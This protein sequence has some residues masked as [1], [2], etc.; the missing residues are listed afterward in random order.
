MVVDVGVGVT[1]HVATAV[2]LRMS[3]SAD[4]SISSST[5]DLFRFLNNLLRV[6]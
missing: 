6:N 3:T 5:F 4:R 1:V 2:G